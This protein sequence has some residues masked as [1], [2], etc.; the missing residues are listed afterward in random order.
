MGLEFPDPDSDQTFAMSHFCPHG[1]TVEQMAQWGYPDIGREYLPQ[2]V[3]TR[4]DNR[5]F[6]LHGFDHYSFYEVA[7]P[8]RVAVSSERTQ[9]HTAIA[10]TTTHR[11][12]NGTYH[13]A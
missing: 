4:V 13:R 1:G 5:P 9:R 8:R 2:L 10:P 6:T 7:V 12:A 3:I 11:T